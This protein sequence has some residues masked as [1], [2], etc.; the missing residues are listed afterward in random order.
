MGI[1]I[2]TGVFIRWE[3]DGGTV[4]LGRKIGATHIL[5]SFATPSM[6]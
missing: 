1:L 2:D 3:R 4:N 5:R 6:A